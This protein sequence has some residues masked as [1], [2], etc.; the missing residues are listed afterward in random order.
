DYKVTGVQT[1]ALPISHFEVERGLPENEEDLA[2]PEDQEHV[3]E[4]DRRR[5]RVA[6]LERQIEVKS[7]RPRL[8]REDLREE[9]PVPDRG[10]LPRSEERRVGKEG[11]QRW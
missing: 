7:R 1:C 11:R 2:L 9:Q 5:D 8:R 10:A 6:A 4:R 3:A